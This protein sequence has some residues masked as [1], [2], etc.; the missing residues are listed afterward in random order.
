MEILSQ[1]T[2][3][4]SYVF[5]LILLG[6]VALGCAAVLLA[7]IS[8]IVRGEV[9]GEYIAGFVV[10]LVFGIVGILGFIDVIKDGPP[11]EYKALI[12]DFNEVYTQG[13]E[14]IERDG[15]LYTISESEAD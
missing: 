11:V 8:E 2:H 12:T 9:Y 15:K 10:A 14:I 13:Y 4:G 5:L 3:W 7:L 1:T 6:A